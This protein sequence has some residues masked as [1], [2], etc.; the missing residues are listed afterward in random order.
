[1]DFL[2]KVASACADYKM[3]EE[4]NA[5]VI[6]LS[7]G[8]DS[9]SLLHAMKQ[10]SGRLGVEVSACHINHHIRGEESD[11]DM[12]FCEEL[13][14]R[15]GI[16]LV[17]RE[18]DV[19]ALQQKHESLEECARRVRY[20]FFAEVSGGKKLATAHNSNDCAETV[21]LNMMRGTGLK[22][23]CG[24]PPVRGNI[25][26]PLI[27]CT[28]ADVEEY[29]RSNDLTWVTDS[30]NLDTDYTRNKIRHIILPEMLKIN[31][32]L[33]PTMNRMERSLR[34]DSDFL[35][36]MAAKALEEARCLGGY[37]AEALAALP[38]PLQSRAIR[39][40]FSA[41]GIEP[42]A[43]R[44]NTAAEILAAGRGKF[45]PCRGKFFVVKRGAAFV[46]SEEQ[47]YKKHE[48]ILP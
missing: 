39:M 37:S 25:I 43:L 26:R 11:R 10:L 48:K 8:A 36:E 2:E 4:G 44:I 9:V 34:S 35:E 14:R 33:F 15:L 13:C 47:H 16:P 28:R 19:P 46:M 12:R 21:L 18:A 45:N 27:Y 22:G 5:V 29:C 23:L 42:S 38:T 41:G 3:I 24:V 40:I 32:S 30:T 31:G 6:A 17:I 1:M 7:G 20:D